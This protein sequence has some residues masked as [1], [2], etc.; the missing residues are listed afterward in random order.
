MDDEKIVANYGFYGESLILL[1]GAITEVITRIDIIRRYIKIKG[2]RD[3]I[4]HVKTR[5]KSEE[6]MKEKLIRKGLA[7]TCENAVTK[8]YDAAGIR[9]ICTF[10]DDVYRIVELL[11]SQQ[12]IKIIE[13]KDYISNPKPSGYRSFH[14][15]IKVP[16]HLPKGIRY[17]NAEIQIRTIAMDC[18]AS[19]EHEMRY[20]KDVPNTE[21]I[22]GELKRCADE[23]ASTDLTLQAIRDMI[24]SEG[25]GGHK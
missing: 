11:K 19:L 10:V 18:W 8:V 2:F 16:I 20:K 1:E 22:A 23:I 15:I 21:L 3:P 9:V 6:S 24:D 7:P 17:V 12:D 4:E 25:T 5:I 14:L 13:E